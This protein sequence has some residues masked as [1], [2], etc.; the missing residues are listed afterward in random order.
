MLNDKGNKYSYNRILHLG[1]N[2]RNKQALASVRTTTMDTSSSIA[3]PAPKTLDEWRN[4]K[5]HPEAFPRSVW[6]PLESFFL[7]HG[8][9]LWLPNLVYGTRPPN[10]APRTPDGFA[11]RTVYCE[12]EPKCIPCFEMTVS[13]ASIFAYQV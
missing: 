1:S 8:Y 3:L 10:K 11:Y 9:I 4:Q 5:L 12:I 13:Q 2:N 6:T 7:S